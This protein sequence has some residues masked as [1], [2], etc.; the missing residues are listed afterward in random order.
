MAARIEELEDYGELVG[1][2]D[3]AFLPLPEA[4][5]CF[6]YRGED[7]GIEGYVFVQPIIVIEPIWVAPKHRGRGVAPKLFGEAV[8][9]LRQGEARGFYCR[10]ER[11]E[12]ESYLRRLG[13]KY[14]GKAFLMELKSEG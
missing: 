4:S 12:V 1:L 9:S 7:G 10:A 14:A 5:R 8:G 3:P 6:V 11:E 13:M 2:V